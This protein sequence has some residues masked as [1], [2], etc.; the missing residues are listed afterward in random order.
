MFLFIA[1]SI[2]GGHP[3][4]IL[5]VGR[6]QNTNYITYRLFVWLIPIY[7]HFIRL[8]INICPAFN[9]VFHFQLIAFS[10]LTMFQLFL[11]LICP[12]IPSFTFLFSFFRHKAIDKSQNSISCLHIHLLSQ[13]QSSQS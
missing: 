9:K 11:C 6:W 12:F 4:T 13:S 3:V 10:I 5:I 2:L 1:Y 8:I 7:E